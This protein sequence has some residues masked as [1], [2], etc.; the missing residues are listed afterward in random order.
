MDDEKIKTFLTLANN[1]SFTKTALLLHKSQSV[2]SRQILSM[3]AEVGFPLFVRD[4]RYCSLTASGKKLAEGLARLEKD[5]QKVVSDA[6]LLQEGKAGTLVIGMHGGESTVR[7][8]ELFTT[9]QK[10]HPNISI[11]FVD[12]RVS[13][14]NNR[15]QDGEIDLAHIVTVGN[16][17]SGLKAL[18]STVPCGVR[19]VCLYIAKGH[20]HFKTDASQL[21]I[22]DFK[23]DTFLLLSEFESDYDSGP[24]ARYLNNLGLTPIVK[25]CDTL[26]S[27]IIMLETGQGIMLS[28]THLSISSNSNFRKLYFGPREIQEEAFAWLPE[29]LNP[30]L[31]IFLDY[32]KQYSKHN[33]EFLTV[34]PLYP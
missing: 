4:S 12:Y 32:L 20:R 14:L 17:Y 10:T 28:S 23:D 11:E 34:D 33:P 5:Y 24:T 9:F 1:L 3:E 2:V 25:G 27:A 16:W 8:N 22:K 31:K 26:T 18:Y 7:Y 15:M 13:E 30:C 19:H 29:N 21:S 6:R